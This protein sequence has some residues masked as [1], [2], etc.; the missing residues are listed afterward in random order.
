MDP[1]LLL[2]LR[3]RFWGWLRRAGRKLGTARGILLTAVGLMIFAPS[4]V[5]VFLDPGPRAAAQIDGFRRFGPVF[6]LVYCLTALLFSPGD[7]AFAFSPAEISFLFPAPFTRRKLLAYKIGGNLGL[8]FLTAIF[9]T[10]A[11]RQNM[12]ICVAGYLGLVLAFS[13]LQLFA[14]A[15][16]LAG[17]AIGERASTRRRQLA[18]ALIIGIAGAT[19][20]SLGWRSFG[21]MGPLEALKK[22]ENAPAVRVALAPFRPFVMAISASRIWPDFLSWAAAALAINAAMIAAILALDAQYLEAAAASSE[23]FYARLERARK[24]GPS[25]SSRDPNKK[26]REVP[27]LPWWGGLGPILWRQLTAAGRDYARVLVAPILTLGFAG[28]AI[29]IGRTQVGP[30]GDAIPL[31]FAGIILGLSLLFSPLLGFDFRGDYERM[32]G[33]KTLPIPASRLALGQ[34]ATP[35]VVITASQLVALL[36]L[37]AGT[38]PVPPAF[39]AFAAFAIPLNVVLLEVENLMFLWFP[40]RPMAHTPGDVQAMGRVMLLMIAKFLVLAVATGLAAAF[41]LLGYLAG[42]WVGMAAVAWLVLMGVSLL[43]VPMIASAFRGFD[44]ASDVIS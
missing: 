12:T 35:A 32:E 28:F 23:R 31:M 41:G 30:D 4:L 27:T 17:Q 19:A 43:L 44:V 7:K 22:L 9:V 33:L 16:T 15:V 5:A 25:V 18:L 20:I 42:G 3:L 29:Y 10:F 39:W 13:F 26:W 24:G 1:A 2:L 6:F 21:G 34:L 40:S 14:M 38:W 36:V 11:M 37:A 8:T